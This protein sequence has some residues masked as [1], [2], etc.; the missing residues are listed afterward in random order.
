MRDSELGDASP[1]LAVSPTEWSA[2]TAV[3]KAGHRNG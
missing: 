1:V 2:F 3:V